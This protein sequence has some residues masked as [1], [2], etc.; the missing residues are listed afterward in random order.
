MHWLM[1]SGLGSDI[2]GKRQPHGEQATSVPQEV[3]VDS[4]R[5]PRPKSFGGQSDIS[6][7]GGRSGAW[8][9]VSLSQERDA[10]GGKLGAA[11]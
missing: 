7:A 10:P 4:F 9:C 3:V 5:A 6:L 11:A 2:C 1:D 8:Y